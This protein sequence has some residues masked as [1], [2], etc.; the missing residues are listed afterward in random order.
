VHVW[1][2]K[3]V[4]VQ[5]N[6]NMEKGDKLDRIIKLQHGDGGLYSHKLIQD[7]FYKYFSNPTLLKGEDAAIISINRGK[8]AYTTD[9]FVV[10]PLFFPGGNIGSLAVCGTINDL[11]VSGARPLYLS[12]GFIIEEGFEISK[13]ELILQS[14]QELCRKTNTIIVTGDTK[15]VEKG[16][17]DNLFIN[18]SGIGEIMDDYKAKTIKAGDEIIITGGIGEHGAVI[19]LKQYGLSIS[20]NLKSDCAPL[21]DIL[22]KIKDYLPRVKL[23][24]DPTR[25]GIATIL[26]EIAMQHKIGILLS[27]ENIPICDEV[28]GLTGLLGLDP[29]YLACEGR[30]ILIVEQGY[31]ESILKKLKEASN[32]KNA[33]RIGYVTYDESEYV[34]L[35]TRI[36]G[37]RRL[38]ML[39]SSMIPRIC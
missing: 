22:L 20:G 29:Y 7:V 25:G 2:Q 11:T 9:S 18:T 5:L 3:K 28:K 32:Y 14:M 39:E 34:C 23:M 31:G 37:K 38:Y 30:M 16:D 19:A 8:L 36:G 15:I 26:N 33:S 6:T 10:K 4:H 13:L 1:F 17:V 21:S 12:V 35:N 27:E 24:K